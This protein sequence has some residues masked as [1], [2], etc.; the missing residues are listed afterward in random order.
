[1]VEI[2]LCLLRVLGWK[3]LVYLSTAD[4]NSTKPSC[5][6]HA[7]FHYFLSDDSNQDAVNTTAQSKHS[8]SFLKDKN[9]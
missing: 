3:I 8:I 7:V 6:R 2:D 1:M 5:K 9:Y 4:I